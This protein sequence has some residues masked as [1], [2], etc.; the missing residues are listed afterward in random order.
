VT[1]VDEA[2]VRARLAEAE[3]LQRPASTR[4]YL[5]P[6]GPGRTTTPETFNSLMTGLEK[7]VFGRLPDATW[8]Y[9]VHGNDTTLGA[10]TRMPISCPPLTGLLGQNAVRSI[11]SA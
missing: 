2:E 5:F 11:I 1:S 4:D 8:I 9:P 10:E 3:Q 6:G 7:R